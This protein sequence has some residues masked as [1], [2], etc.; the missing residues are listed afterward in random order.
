MAL[1]YS[2]EV[3]FNTFTRTKI[4]REMH[5]PFNLLFW[6]G[7]HFPATSIRVPL[8]HMAVDQ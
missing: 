4:M 1:T 8:T 6:F 7:K 5:E 2:V 3:D